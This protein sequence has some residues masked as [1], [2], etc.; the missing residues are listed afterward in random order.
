M[1]LCGW[2][3]RRASGAGRWSPVYTTPKSVSVC[4]VYALYIV[5]FKVVNTYQL[6]L[7]VMWCTSVP[8]LVARSRVDM[9]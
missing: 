5:L 9:Y 8:S 4:S 6:D 7:R 1:P 2:M 3:G